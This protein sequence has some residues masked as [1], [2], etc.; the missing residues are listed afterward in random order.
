MKPPA[1]KH[2]DI[3]DLT[4]TACRWPYGD[5]PFTY[6]GQTKVTGRPYCE[7]HCSIAYTKVAVRK[8][9]YVR[10]RNRAA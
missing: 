7:Y 3:T 6:C 4:A 8:T 1:P 5:G 9:S 10:F 2:L